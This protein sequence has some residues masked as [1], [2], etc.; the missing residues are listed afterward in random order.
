[1]HTEVDVDNSSGAL[2]DGMYADVT[3]VLRQ[4]KGALTVPVQAVT[5]NGNT[6]TVLVVDPQ[7][8]LEPRQV[9]LGMESPNRVEVVSGLEANDRVVIGSASAFHAGEKVQPKP[10]Q[11]AANNT[12]EF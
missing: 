11:Q 10:F 6:A 2:V 8:R 12:E 1:M 3:L 4:R 5:R 9:R 7:D